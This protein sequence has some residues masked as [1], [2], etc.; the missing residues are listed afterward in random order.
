VQEIFQCWFAVNTLLPGV[1]AC[2]VRFPDRASLTQVFGEQWKQDRLDQTWNTITEMIPVLQ[3][4]RLPPAR[5][6]WSFEQG[7]LHFILRPDGIALGLFT[8]PQAGELPAIQELIN[9]FLTLA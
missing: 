5:M 1:H 4:Q 6:L 2:C 9:G 8:T 3:A 7:E